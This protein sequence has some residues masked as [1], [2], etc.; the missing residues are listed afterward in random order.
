MCVCIH[1]TCAYVGRYEV[2]VCTYTL[3]YAILTWA[4][5]STYK[6]WLIF[7]HC[8]VCKQ[9]LLVPLLLKQQ[10]IQSTHTYTCT[11]KASTCQSLVLV[12]GYLCRCITI[13][14][15]L[16]ACTNLPIVMV[17]HDVVRFDVSVHYSHT[18][19]VVECS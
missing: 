9:L 10:S 11:H 13:A 17:Y 7:V 4:G 2:S 19:A 12:V 16:E 18:V 8:T 5:N 3:P 1:T 15:Q 14:T 6:T